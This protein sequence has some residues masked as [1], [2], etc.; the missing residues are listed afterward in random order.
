MKYYR[1]DTL[2]SKNFRECSANGDGFRII[3]WCQGCPIHCEGCHNQELWDFSEGKKFTKKQIDNILTELEEDMYSGITF[4]GGEP[5]D[6]HNVNG[7]LE[8]STAIREKFR[9]SKTIWCYTGY[10]FE[11]LMNQPNQKQLIETLD[12]LVDGPFILNRRDISLKF[13]GS[14]NQ[15]L[16]DIP[17]TIQN[18]KVILYE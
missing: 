1:I 18:N 2:K 8:L 14:D 7:F 15:R 16:I 6:E 12:V 3:V 5:M 4:L 17:K 11:D 13:R 9:K 10:K